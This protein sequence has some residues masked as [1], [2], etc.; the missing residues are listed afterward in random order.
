[1]SSTRRRTLVLFVVVAAVYCVSPA[2]QDT[3]AFL[4]LPT[5]WAVVHHATL[6]LD[7]FHTPAITGYYAVARV[8]GHLVNSFPW[9]NSL[10]LIPAV[11]VFDAGHA[12]GLCPSALAVITGNHRTLLDAAQLVSAS[13]VTAGAAAVLYTVLVGRFAALEDAAPGTES[14][15]ARRLATLV[16]LAFAFGTSAWSTASR[17][18][19][20][21]GPSLLLLALAVWCADRLDRARGRPG[22]NAGCLGVVLAAAYTVRPTNALPVVVLTFWV[23]WRHRSELAWELLGG[24][25]IGAIWI[26]VNEVTYGAVLPPYNAADRLT[27]AGSYPEAF[28]ANLFS[29]SRGLVVFAPIVI[30]GG[31]GFFMGRARWSR[32]LDPALACCIVGHLVVIAA[33]ADHWWAG[34]SYGPRFTTDLLV[35]AA[36]LSVPAVD[37]L[38]RAGPRPRARR[39]ALVACLVALGWSV[40]T[41]GSGAVARS[42]WCWNLQPDNID[43]NPGRV[44]SWAH[45][46]FLTPVQRLV[47]SGSLSQAV[48]GHC[49][50]P[51]SE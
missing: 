25:A 22:V 29:P 26:A 6:H 21:H 20:E 49:R 5:A 47:D 10:L 36:V 1:V 17:A 32:G 45:P 12:L 44:W 48:I 4:T 8:H 7:S 30:V 40:F 51:T 35:Y 2:T 34:Q 23:A 50:V 27:L 15:R 42:A 37:R 16:T 11:V 18:M 39:V 41:N 28:A 3:D 9:P 33:L 14:G 38:A 31:V 24:G 19:W 13:L 43:N 46:Q